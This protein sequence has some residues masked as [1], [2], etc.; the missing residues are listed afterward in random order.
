[1]TNMTT[2][3]HQRTRRYSPPWILLLVT[4]MA[5]FWLSTQATAQAQSQSQS[6]SQIKS[7]QNTR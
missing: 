6:Q 7:N 1:M 2:G 5:C 4:L 3:I